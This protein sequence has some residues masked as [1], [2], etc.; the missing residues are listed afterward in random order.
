FV[1]VG[2]NDTTVSHDTI[3]VTPH[4]P[5]GSSVHY[6]AEFTFTGLARFAAPL[7]KPLLDRLGDRTAEQLKST[8]DR[9]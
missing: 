3:T 1:I 9:L 2:R 6:R 4:G 5:N 8:L 7:M